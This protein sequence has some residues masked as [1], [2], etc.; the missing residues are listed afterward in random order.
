[1]AILL[2]GNQIL[3]ASIMVQN[4][5]KIENWDPEAVRHIALNSIR[6]NYKKFHFEYGRL[7]LCFDSSNNW[8][9]KIFP[10]YKYKRA[11]SRE[12]AS[13]AEIWKELFGFIQQLANDLKEY[14]PYQ[15]MQV[16]TTEAD[17]IIA[18]LANELSLAGEKTLIVSGDGDFHQLLKLPRIQQWNP[19]LKRWETSSDPDDELLEQI[20]TGCSGDSVPNVM[21]PDNSFADGIRQTAMT[22]DR[23][24]ELKNPNSSLRQDPRWA[25]NFQRNEALIDLSKIPTEVQILILEEFMKDWNHDKSKVG[26]YL[27]D[28]GAEILLT[29]LGDF[30][31]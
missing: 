7:I 1:M 27:A 10:H 22:K 14:F 18:V 23:I 4:K 26:N 30:V 13:V 15:V 5:G 16:D 3:I 17:D 25:K 12:D 9:R 28:H 24:R 31:S 19:I 20:C 2:D 29:H 11:K 21:S 6:A 8:R